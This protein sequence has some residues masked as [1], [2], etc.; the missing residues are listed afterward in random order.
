MKMARATMEEIEDVAWLVGIL[1]D[2]E[3]GQWPRSALREDE[4]EADDP[5]YFDED[6][7]EHC[8]MLVKRVLAVMAR[9]NGGAIT[10][11]VLGMHTVCSP[12]N[13]IVNQ[14][15]EWL[16]IHHGLRPTWEALVA[17]SETE[18]EEDKIN[19]HE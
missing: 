10:R 8:S 11:V 7:P 1:Q 2:V 6:D 14:E 19:N 16:E 17:E 9:M 12:E 15:S 13:K 4:P 18:K 5:D 3:G